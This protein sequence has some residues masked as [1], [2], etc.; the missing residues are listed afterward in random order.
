MPVQD[1]YMVHGERI[2]VGQIECGRVTAGDHLRLLP[3][4]GQ[5][6][7]TGV[8]EFG[9]DR[10]AAECGE[11]IG[12]TLDGGDTAARGQVLASADDAP[13]HTTRT[14]R[15]AICWLASEPL[16]RGEALVFRCATQ[17]AACRVTRILQ[18]MDSSSLAFSE[19]DAPRLYETEIGQVEIATDPP[20]LIESFARI[21][22][23]GRFVLERNGDIVAGGIIA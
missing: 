7:V 12:L 4:E 8:R 21:P 17:D 15:G 16:Q 1:V 10:Q 2:V 11:N 19:A 6:I 9:H 23:L 5:V 14:V 22:A 13:P 3:G 18:R 20:V